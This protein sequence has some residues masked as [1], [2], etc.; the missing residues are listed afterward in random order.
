MSIPLLIGFMLCLQASA[1]YPPSDVIAG[2]EFD[3]ALVDQRAP[4]SDN[5]PCTW[6]TDGHLYT[7]WG[8]GGGFGGTNSEGRVSLG[9]ARVEGPADHYTGINVWGG[10]EA[11]SRATF[12]GKSYGI[13]AVGS[14][15]YLW[16]SPGSGL[17]NNREARLA[18]SS[19]GGRSWELADWAF[20]AD[21][22]VAL[23]AFCQFGPGNT[24]APGEYAYLYAPKLLDAQGDLQ[25]P[26]EVWLMR[27]PRDRVMDRSAYEFYGGSGADGRN[28]SGEIEARQPVFQD[29]EGVR[30]L[31]VSYHPGLERYLLC[32]EHTESHR[33]NLGVF[34][35]PSPWGPWTTVLYEERW[36]GY[37]TAFYW[38]FP[39]KWFEPNGL[40]FTLVFTG[41]RTLDAWNAVPG[42][43]ILR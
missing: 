6:S 2:V 27:V 28:W 13:L 31:S 35:A 25:R 24:G 23:P 26:G 21:Q 19:D 4:G 10:V 30:L 3:F 16:V 37:D 39:T 20:T 40:G 43:F 32:T 29:P 38:N 17:E 12:G 11:E 14:T 36:G 5:W 33:S 8:D 1:P 42:R 9:V 41:T 15:L 34:D 22:Q 7:T 18:M